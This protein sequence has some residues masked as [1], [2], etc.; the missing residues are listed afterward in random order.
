MMNLPPLSRKVVAIGAG[1]VGLVAVAA[2]ALRIRALLATT[3]EQRHAALI[4]SLP[5]DGKVHLFVM[6]RVRIA[7][8]FSPY[9]TKVEAF[10][11]ANKIPHEMH[12]TWNFRQ[13]PTG[14]LPFIVCKDT[15]LGES[16]AIIE[17]LTTEFRANMDAHL[18]AERRG[19]GHAIREAIVWSIAPAMTRTIFCIDRLRTFSSLVRLPAPI[20]FLLSVLRRRELNKNYAITGFDQLSREQFEEML[21]DDFMALEELIRERGFLLGDRMTSVDCDLYGHLNYYVHALQ[22]TGELDREPETATVTSINAAGEETTVTVEAPPKTLISAPVSYVAHSPVFIR[23]VQTIT[24]TL[25]DGV[26]VLLEPLGPAAAAE[27]DGDDI[28]V[29]VEVSEVALNADGEMP[30]A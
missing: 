18:S 25:F 16:N 27:V 1:V 10:L 17:W 9:C 24:K 23:Y 15:I 30:T 11:R 4:A 21:L 19:E 3:P 29:D 14:T 2:A 20:M 13:S 26:E 8:S 12:F 28:D 22:V 6:P 5:D 7:P